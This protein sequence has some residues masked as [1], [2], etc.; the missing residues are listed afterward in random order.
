M[1]QDETIKEAVRKFLP[2][3]YD[4][5]LFKAQLWQESRLNPLARSP[6]GARGAAQIM[7]N[8]WNYIAPKCGHE[9]SDP[10]DFTASV[11][12]GA[13]YLNRMLN[14]WTAPRPEGDKLALALASYNAGF[15][16][17]LR[18]QR[19]ADGSNNYCDIAQGLPTITGPRNAYETVNYVQIIV[20]KYWE[21]ILK[22]SDT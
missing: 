4:W 12:V 9:D 13:F 1:T 22:C 17:M 6:A 20:N 19:V 16:N 21:Y 18:A 15:G 7:P 8:T 2:P 10:Y 14:K 3:N 11:E 5:R